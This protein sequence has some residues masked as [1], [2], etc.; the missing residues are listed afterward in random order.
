VA[1]FGG[2]LMAAFLVAFGRRS[3]ASPASADCLIRH[4]WP[5]PVIRVFKAAKQK[6]CMAGTSPAMTR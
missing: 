1:V 6:T 2:V 5:V 3:C 4:A